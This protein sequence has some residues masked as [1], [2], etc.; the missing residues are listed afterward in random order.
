MAASNFENKFTALPSN[1]GGKATPLAASDF[2]YK[3]IALPSNIVLLCLK[4]G[5]R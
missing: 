4:N 1:S 3:F 5:D 2:G